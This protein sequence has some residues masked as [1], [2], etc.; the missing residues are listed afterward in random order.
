MIQEVLSMWLGKQQKRACQTGE[1][2]VGKVTIGGDQAAVLLDS[3]RRGLEVYAPGGY[4][5]TP[6]AG[7][8]VLV[9]QGQ[10]EVPCVVG[11]RQGETPPETVTIEADGGGKLRLDGKNSALA[12]E[13]IVLDGTVYVK[14]ETLE[15]LIE[16]IVVDLLASMG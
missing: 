13:K 1:G 4:H 3:E 15:A 12:G 9:I 2:Q 10:G 5:W 11:L 16:R 8:K 6:R 7:Q 14:S